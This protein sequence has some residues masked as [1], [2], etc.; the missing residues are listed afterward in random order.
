MES[1]SSSSFFKRFVAGS[2]AFIL[3]FLLFFGKPTIQW[4]DDS[5][6]GRA[7]RKNYF[8]M[9]KK[10]RDEVDSNG[11]GRVDIWKLYRKGIPSELRVD[12]NLDGKMDAWG[13]YGEKEVILKYRADTDFDGRIDWSGTYPISMEKTDE[14]P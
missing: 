12:T 13:Q 14:K 8:W 6:D 4:V 1:E 11:D 9:G 10:L 2:G 5:H 3:S 7:E